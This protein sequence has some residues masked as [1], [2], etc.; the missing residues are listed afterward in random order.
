MQQTGILLPAHL[1]NHPAASE[2]PLFAVALIR[3]I[4]NR[5][6]FYFETHGCRIVS[7]PCVIV[8]VVFLRRKPS[9]LLA[10]VPCCNTPKVFGS[11]NALQLAFGT[12]YTSQC[13]IRN[14]HSTHAYMFLPF[15]NFGTAT[16][17]NANC[18]DYSMHGF[19]GTGLADSEKAR[20]VLSGAIAGRS[21]T[22]WKQRADNKSILIESHHVLLSTICVVRAYVFLVVW[23]T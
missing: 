14:V 8:G 7:R 12:E 13:C 22:F 20:K 3:L 2:Q 11:A 6:L 9:R 19:G 1:E 17:G 16:Y 18:R 21:T 10:A 4:P 23:P 5:Q 15:N